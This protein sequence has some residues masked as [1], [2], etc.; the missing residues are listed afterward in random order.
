MLTVMSVSLTRLTNGFWNWYG[1]YMFTILQMCTEDIIKQG[2][3][4][5]WFC[6]ITLTVISLH[7]ITF[8]YSFKIRV[9]KVT[10]LQVWIWYYHVCYNL[11]FEH[12]TH[13]TFTKLRTPGKSLREVF[14]TD[15][16]GSAR[17]SISVFVN[18]VDQMYTVL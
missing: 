4:D 6:F 8:S 14:M 13:V 18:P 17:Y 7:Q 2:T 11:V 15:V 9:M 16:A 10:S 5:K 3:W 12:N 1:I